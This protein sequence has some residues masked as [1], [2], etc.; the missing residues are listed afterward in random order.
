M[1]PLARPLLGDE[2]SAA[3]AEVLRSGM[4]VQGPR[5]QAFEALLQQRCRREHAV[6]VS[7]GTAALYLALRALGIGPGDHVLCPDLTWPS[8]ANAV[9]LNG[10]QPVL[11]DVDP[12]EWNAT[13]QTLA[14]ARTSQTRAAIVIDQFGNP[15]RTQQIAQALPGIPLL[16]DAACSLG[17]LINAAPCGSLGTISCISFHPRKVI[18]TGEG[19]ICLTDDPSLAD[20]LRALR[21]HG[22]DPSSGDFILHA[23]NLRMSEIAAAIGT[24]QMSRL[25][26]MLDA[27]R[28]LGNRYQ[29]SLSP[30][31][32]TGLQRAP[33]N[34]LPNFQTFGVILP[35]HLSGPGRDRVIAELGQHQ[36]QTSLLGHALHRLQPFQRFAPQPA[37]SHSALPASA[38]IALRGLALP[39]FPTMT[40]SQQ[41]KV[42]DSLKNVLKSA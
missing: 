17:S 4:L 2:E 29:A 34:A 25:D 14:A 27:R 13:P 23:T 16:V 31:S 35:P 8:P 7:S 12:D 19:G 42:V 26:T 15:A 20:K 37:P 39:L 1:I 24:V 18:T 11:V 28:K 6:A 5:V 22:L 38:A 36:I 33:E 3:A 30:L 32:S 21:N 9:I 10:A 40:D 41:D